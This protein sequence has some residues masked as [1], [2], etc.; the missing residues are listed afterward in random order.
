MD[1][2]RINGP[3]SGTCQ[4]IY[5]KSYGLG[6]FRR[7]VPKAPI[8]RRPA[9]EL[10]KA[11]LQTGT[12]PSA[13]GSAYLELQPRDP[14]FPKQTS[15]AERSIAPKLSC[16]VHGPRPLPRSEPFSPH[17]LLS[18]NIKFAS[19]ASRRRRGYMA[20]RGERDLSTHLET[21][22]RGMII[23][24]RWPKSSVEV[25]ITI[26][27]GD[28]DYWS[29]G[30]VKS[31]TG[32]TNWGRMTILAACITVASAAIADAG[33][34]CLDMV[35][36]GTAALVRVKELDAKGQNPVNKLRIVL[37]PAPSEHDNIQA[38]CVVG[39]MPARNEVTEIWMN[40]G[41]PKK[42][43]SAGTG[44]EQVKTGADELTDHAILA[45][46]GMHSVVR[47]AIEEIG[48]RKTKQAALNG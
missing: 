6:K 9:R 13:S 27:E 3:P 34:D 40:G 38:L 41:T 37:D 24:E 28:E 11:F 47:E 16:V 7:Y 45:A 35:V 23:A 43:G 18:T 39:Y 29:G 14:P 4:P 42:M 30:K 48:M 44:S 17:L 31:A 46:T 12:I 15:L 33:I 26:L 25:V 5:A 8:R 32:I 20:S 22:L 1:R 36:G 19:F 10:R 2:R 21:A